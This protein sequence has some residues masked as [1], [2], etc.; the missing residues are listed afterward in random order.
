MKHLTTTI[1]TIDQ[2]V[3]F[4][5][6]T[7]TKRAAKSARSILIQLF[8]G[9]FDTKRTGDIVNTIRGILPDAVIVTITSAGEISKGHIS[10][11]STAISLS[12]FETS[13]L[14]PI[15]Q[16]CQPG[17]EYE[18]GMEI[19]K[20]LLEI[21]SLKGLLLLARPTIINCARLLDGINNQLSDIVVFGGGAANVNSSGLPM[22][23][24][25]TDA[26]EVAAVALSGEN[27]HV[28]ARAF[29]GW[30]ALGPH[31]TLTKVEGFDIWTIDDKPAIDVYQKYLSIET[32]DDLFLLEFPL[33]IDRQ[34]TMLARNPISSNKDGH[35]SLVA[36]VYSGESARLGYLD[37]DSVIENAHNVY[38]AMETFGPEAIY[39]YS[40][41]CRRFALQQDTELETLPFQKIA[42]VAGFFTYGEFCQTGEQLQLF[43]SSQVFVALRE[44]NSSN[45]PHQVKERK[46]PTAID[47]YRVRHIRITSRFFHFISALTEEVE[48]ANRELQFQADHDSLT[49][50][51]NRRVLLE[52]SQRELT[53]SKR[54]KHKLSIIMF[55]IDHF[56]RFNDEYG[57][58]TG[59]YVLKIVAATVRGFMRA[60]DTLYRYGGE[61]F[62]LLLPETPMSGAMIF[63]ERLR[64]GI[65]FLSLYHEG[66]KLATITA[67]F[68]VAAYQEDG[69]D[70][71]T[72]INAADMALYS[73]KNKGRNCVSK[74][75]ARAYMQIPK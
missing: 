3:E 12:F 31:M 72:I 56:K 30:K 10:L 8:V 52:N 32:G 23:Y 71:T 28:E 21:P 54:Y 67:S 74:T 9:N 18:T 39:L 40:C 43:N 50:V 33:L 41:I 64:T 70:I 2:V 19:A 55:D 38:A 15:A 62:L 27:L 65:E 34:G 22:I 4:L 49:G 73:S 69:D 59:D 13:V 11:E 61:E 44:G 48:D 24:L 36:D 35:V 45:T 51:L 25:N 42:P 66:N 20:K 53:R 57:H 46:A 29:L 17:K 63:A 5:G 75:E 26:V 16:H 1:S 14:H 68:G 47:S 58:A 7:A 6:R 37:V 60:S